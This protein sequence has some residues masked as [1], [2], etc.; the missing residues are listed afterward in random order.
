[1]RRFW[2]ILTV[3]LGAGLVAAVPGPPGPSPGLEPGQVVR[4]QV[5]ALADNGASNDGIA[6]AYRFAA[7]SNR[8]L[9]GP[10]PRFEQLVRSAPY[11]RLLNH[12]IAHFGELSVTGDHA[13]QE[14][15]IVDWRGQ[16]TVYRWELARQPAGT[17][18][19]LGVSALS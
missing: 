12:Q 16:A 18:A 2:M 4:I 11:A 10:L 5:Q 17:W 19:G 13:T 1:M 3:G 8:Q 15:I 9:T 14:V 7:P 6:L